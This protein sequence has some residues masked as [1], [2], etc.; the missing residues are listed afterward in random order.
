[1]FKLAVY[2]LSFSASA[3]F[4]P[5]MASSRT[6]SGLS[7]SAVDSATYTFTKSEEIFAEAQTVRHRALVPYF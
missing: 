2:A 4:T 6:S 1:M 7:M 5:L 3:A